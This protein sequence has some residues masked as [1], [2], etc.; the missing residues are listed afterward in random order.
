MGQV[1]YDM[2]FLSS[3]EV[4]ECSTSDL[5]GQYVG[6]TGPRTVKLLEKALGRILFIDEAYRLGD[7]LFAKEAV[8]ELVSN[9]T[10]E[11]FRGKIIV[12]LAGYDQEMNDM[13]AVNPGL[14]SRFTEEVIFTNMPIP[15][16]FEL[17]RMELS[18][19]QIRSSALADN[20]SLDYQEVA[21]LL[22]VLSSMSSWGNGRDLKELSKRMISHVFTS[23]TIV[24]DPDGHTT[25]PSADVVACIR[26]MLSQKQGRST[27]SS[28]PGPSRLQSLLPT[29]SLGP[30]F[31][32]PPPNLQTSTVTKEAPAP[33]ELNEIPPSTP[34]EATR[35]PGVSDE[36]WNQLQADRRAEELE[37]KI[38]EEE[39]KV[40]EQTLQEARRKKEEA[41][42][43]VARALAAEKAARDDA[44]RNELMRRREEARLRQIAVREEQARIAQIQE[45]RRQ[46]E[47][48]K[49]KEEARVQAKIR[50]MGICPAGFQWIKQASG[51]RCA[52]GSHFLSN[53]ALGI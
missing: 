25:L 1:F 32:P 13:L 30:Q 50:Q 8:D 22:T 52:G 38:F 36:V 53:G 19:K 49:R 7:G 18:K 6:Q 20:S 47:E 42:Q 2:G 35:D 40:I 29:Q 48:R 23:Q 41:A 9:L 33:P 5:V 3:T 27:T 51:Y 44:E 14:S 26:S 37:R 39:K 43:E 46:E 21:Q 10:L 15:Q 24:P 31:S 17:L 28:M 12:I 34:Q 11:R 45:A 16:C 4:I